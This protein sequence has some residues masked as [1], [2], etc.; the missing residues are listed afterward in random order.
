MSLS[1][2]FDFEKFVAPQLIRF[3]YW[4]GLILIGLSVVSALF[5]GGGAIGFLG[6]LIMSVI[7]GVAGVLIWRVICEVWIVMFSINDRLTE[8]AEKGRGM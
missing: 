7:G 2:L 8:I 6:R 1:D 5:S 4:I 3:V